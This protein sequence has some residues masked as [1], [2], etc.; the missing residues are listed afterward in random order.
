MPATRNLLALILVSFLIISCSKKENISGSSAL[1]DYVPENAGVV[2][3]INTGQMRKKIDWDYI[4]G[5]PML[6]FLKLSMKDN[7]LIKFFNDAESTGLN[8]N[9]EV[10][11]YSIPDTA[12]GGKNLI[13]SIVQLQ[14]KKKFEEMIRSFTKTETFITNKNY[15]ACP[16]K[17]MM[18]G[19]DKEVLIIVQSPAE[20]K[21]DGSYLA[22]YLE[23]A[24]SVS[25]K[26]T[27][28]KGIFADMVSSTA[29]IDIWTDSGSLMQ[30]IPGKKD[31][32]TGLDASMLYAINFNKG[33]IS[34]DVTTNPK[35]ATGVDIMKKVFNR[36]PQNDL[37]QYLPDNYSVLM[38]VSADPND[39]INGLQMLT[40]KNILD[41]MRNHLDSSLS[42]ARIA[43][44]VDQVEGDGMFT[45]NNLS[46]KSNY[47]PDFTLVFNV[48]TDSA[49]QMFTAV[50]K[51]HRITKQEAITQF[52]KGSDTVYAMQKDKI[53]FI[54]GNRQLLM[55]A[56]DD[57]KAGK[58]L[59][60]AIS[61]AIQKDPFVLYA[62]GSGLSAEEPA[63]TGSMIQLTML[64]MFEDA[65][66]IA[67]P[68]QQDMHHGHITVHLTNKSDYSIN[69]IIKTIL[70]SAGNMFKGN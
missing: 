64:S 24:F 68:V 27:D 52:E 63:L 35:D 28:H 15:T 40:G 6:A 45:V 9:N 67:E 2:V 16:G 1:F 14:D 4:N 60:P 54:S 10:I 12:A 43:E 7:I 42:D 34:I 5:N 3:N 44:I 25:Q 66:I 39:V 32:L 22:P 20:M 19:W 18:A 26:L 50:A 46:P 31:T 30:Y 21:T 48:K 55:Q 53:V 70:D 57:K 29:D 33:D 11:C 13:Y 37:L 47:H 23:K 58:Q 17:G 41:H 62:D 36:T 61:S 49:L 65:E 38:H 51:D 69:V 8:F 59:K 56:S